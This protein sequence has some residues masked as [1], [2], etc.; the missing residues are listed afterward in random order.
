M[1][2]AGE[3]K[4]GDQ[5]IGADNRTLAILGIEKVHLLLSTFE[6]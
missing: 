1:A 3:L 5:L 6:I 4:V 2:T